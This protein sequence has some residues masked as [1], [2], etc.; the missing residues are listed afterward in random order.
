MSNMQGRAET[1]A[2]STEWQS[3]HYKEP[4]YSI[5]TAKLPRKLRE[6][7]ILSAPRN[8]YILDAC[9]GRGEAL[10]ALHKFGFQNLHG[11]DATPQPSSEVRPFKLHHGNVQQMPFPDGTFDLIINLHALHHMGGPDGVAQFLGECWRVLKPGGKLAIIDFP[12]SP[13]IHLV[14]WLLRKRLFTFTGGLRNFAEI[15]DEEW[16]YLEP[17]LQ[18]WPAVKRVLEG[19]QFRTVRRRQ[20]PFLYYW[21]MLSLPPGRPI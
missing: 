2:E 18:G 12:G 21:T 5:R 20:R 16:S 3:A 13:Q 9:C 1:S 17:Y 11:I 6:L 7:G 14:F 4:Y 19:P 8:A 15:V 10:D